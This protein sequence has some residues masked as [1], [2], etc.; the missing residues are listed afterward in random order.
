MR[1]L[2]ADKQMTWRSHLQISNKIEACNDRRTQDY[3]PPSRRILFLD[4]EPMILRVTARL[5]D[6]LGYESEVSTSGVETLARFRHAQESD[7]PFDAVILDLTAPGDMGGLE[8]LRELKKLNP[9]TRAI[10][11]SDYSEDRNY[12]VLGFSGQLRKPF[13]VSDVQRV[14]RKVLSQ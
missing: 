6:K 1:V 9:K 8:V 4:D 3:G 10:L 7:E 13:M 5:L 2:K 12:S 14:L 11:A